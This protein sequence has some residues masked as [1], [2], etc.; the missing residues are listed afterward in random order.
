MTPVC[1][2]K[3]AWDRLNE[4]Y[5]G[6]TYDLFSSMSLYL[7]FKKKLP[8]PLNSMLHCSWKSAFNEPQGL[9]PYSQMPVIEPYLEQTPST[10]S[11]H[12]LFL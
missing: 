8:Y 12:I 10:S 4:T 9:L 6:S 1:T 7:F 5:F 3:A 2:V 11:V